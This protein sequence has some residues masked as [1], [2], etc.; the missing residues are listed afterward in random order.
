MTAK[1]FLAHVEDL[2]K[3]GKEDLVP[4][5]ILGNGMW[6][7]RHAEEVHEPLQALY[8]KYPYPAKSKKE[9][10]DK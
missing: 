3:S 4:G 5:Y 8:K 6:L 2:L 10:S 9:D 1:K 7:A